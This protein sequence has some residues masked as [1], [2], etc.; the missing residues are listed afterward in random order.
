MLLGIMIPLNLVVGG[1]VGMTVWNWFM[2]LIFGL[3]VLTLWAAIA[4][5]VVRSVFIP[6]YSPQQVDKSWKAIGELQ[7]KTT[8]FHLLLI[9]T[10]YIVHIY[11]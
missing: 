1:W 6:S 2:P 8:F 5:M 10:G 3:P 4:I 9:A 11:M 7:F